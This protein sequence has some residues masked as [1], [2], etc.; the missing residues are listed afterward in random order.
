MQ[1]WFELRNAGAK[2]IECRFEVRIDGLRRDQV[3]DLCD[4]LACARIAKQSNPTSAIAVTDVRTGKLV[5][6]V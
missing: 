5:L 6:E 2:L 4:A 3:Y 1:L